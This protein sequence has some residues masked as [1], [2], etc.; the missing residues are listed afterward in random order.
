MIPTIAIS[1]PTVLD[2]GKNVMTA[3][4]T[5]NAKHNVEL[6]PYTAAGCLSPHSANMFGEL[7]GH[8]HM[9]RTHSLAFAVLHICVQIKKII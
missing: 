6:P 3:V 7:A 1:S 4:T 9:F 8:K 5:G 2:L